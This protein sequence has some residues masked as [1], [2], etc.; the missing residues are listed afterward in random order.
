MEGVIEI[1]ARARDVGY[2]A[3]MRAAADSGSDLALSLPLLYF[4]TSETPPGARRLFPKLRP[5][6]L[7]SEVA[8]ES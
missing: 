1:W 3:G 4:S 6:E 5:I 2:L 7:P 8:R